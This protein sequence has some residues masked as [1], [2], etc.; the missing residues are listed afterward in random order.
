MGLFRNEASPIIQAKIF[1]IIATAIIWFLMLYI[2]LKLHT[3]IQ[4]SL[5]HWEEHRQEYS[6]WRRTT[7]DGAVRAWGTILW[8]GALVYENP[9]LVIPIHFLCERQGLAEQVRV[10]ETILWFFVYVYLFQKLRND[11]A[12]F[13][14]WWTRRVL[15]RGHEHHE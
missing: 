3:Y 9:L 7:G 12:A 8:L 13:R 15:E 6:S 14:R 4:K 10:L 5:V 1:S 11:F 2:S